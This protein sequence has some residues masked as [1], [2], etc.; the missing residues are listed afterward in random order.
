[1]Q[2]IHITKTARK[3]GAFSL[4]AQVGPFDVSSPSRAP[5]C[6][7][8]I[9]GPFFDFGPLSVVLGFWPKST[10]LDFGPSR[11][12]CV[13]PKLVLHFKATN[14]TTNATTGQLLFPPVASTISLYHWPLF[15]NH[16]LRPVFWLLPPLSLKKKK[17]SLVRFTKLKLSKFSTLSLRGMLEYILNIF[18]LMIYVS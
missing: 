6:F 14:V 17:K 10:P 3:W 18:T 13:S 4:L 2:A 7:G 11:L 8:P 15:I 9:V 16:Q 1:M 12:S 5:F